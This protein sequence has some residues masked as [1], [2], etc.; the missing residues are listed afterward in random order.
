MSEARPLTAIEAIAKEV[1]DAL[2]TG[3]QIPSISARHADF[4]LDQ[5][6]AVTAEL[7]RL[8][9]A[10]GESQVGR[11]IGFTNRTIWTQYGVHAP[12]WG[13]MYGTT[14]RNVGA[15]TEFRLGHLPEPLIEPEIVFGLGRAPEPDMDERALI[16]C[17]DWV[18]HGFEIVQS[19]FPQWKFTPADTVAANGLH[20]A[21]LIGPRHAIGERSTADWLAALANFEIALHRDGVLIDRGQAELVLGG[22]LSALAHLN[23]ML[24]NDPHNPALHA[25]EIVTTGTVTRAFPVTA[26]QTWNTDV[27]GIVLDPLT[28]KFA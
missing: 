23:R 7:R 16:G 20:G 10:R 4:G 18:A 25:G 1:A 11:K 9:E 21:L 14:V 19:I 2:A 8:R 13:D 15:R 5:A 27:S 28:V 24:Q 12:I 3:R 26:G 22:P 6:Y 17:I